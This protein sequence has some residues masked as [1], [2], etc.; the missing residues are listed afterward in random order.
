MYDIL[1]LNAKLVSELQDIAM[2]LNIPNIEELKKQELIYEILDHQ[3]L[4]LK[5]ST[6]T[7]KLPTAP[8]NMFKRW[9]KKEENELKRLIEA[10]ANSAEIAVQ[11]NRTRIAVHDKK[12]KLG[13][14]V[15]LASARKSSVPYVAYHKNVL[16]APV[17]D[18]PVT[19][20]AETPSII[21]K[22]TTITPFGEQIKSLK[23][24]AKELGLKVTV[25][26]EVDD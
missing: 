12:A 14:D 7:E 20:V 9:T 21:V 11:L 2:A 1:E 17:T 10:G 22:K 13:I 18:A 19:E 25:F 26:I 16:S 6:M 23:D 24:S 15:R 4:K 3:A 5:H 8:S